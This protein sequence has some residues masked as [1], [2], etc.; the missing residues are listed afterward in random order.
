MDG[1]KELYI[2]IFFYNLTRKHI[3]LTCFESLLNKSVRLTNFY[4]SLKNLKN[5]R[6]DKNLI[7]F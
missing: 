7:S 2:Y 5:Q 3:S 4:S 1:P 6:N